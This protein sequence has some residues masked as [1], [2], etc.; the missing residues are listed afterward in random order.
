[1]L[2]LGTKKAIQEPLQLALK[3]PLYQKIDEKIAEAKELLEQNSKISVPFL[4]RKLKVSASM[5][6]QIRDQVLIQH[7]INYQTIELSKNRPIEKEWIENAQKDLNPIA[8][9][10]NRE[11]YKRKN[12]Y[13]STKIGRKKYELSKKGKIARKRT[14]ALRDRRTKKIN[15]SEKEKE[16]I[17]DFYIQCPQGFHVDHI[18]PLSKGGG[19]ALSNLQWLTRS[20]NSRK[21][22]RLPKIETEYPHCLV[23]RDNFK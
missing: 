21:K 22:D 15:F 7:K 23:N 14:K 6:K 12:S 20:Q 10:W 3:K 18:I 2:N 4:M 11:I 9:E 13:I 8:D 5:A 1:M 16:L 19:H 17:R